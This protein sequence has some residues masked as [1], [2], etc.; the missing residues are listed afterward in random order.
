MVPR[1]DFK[2]SLKKTAGGYF[3]RSPQQDELSFNM[4]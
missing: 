4:L 1:G 3:N 2:V